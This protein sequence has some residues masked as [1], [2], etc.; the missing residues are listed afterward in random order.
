MVRGTA[1][2]LRGIQWRHWT[3]WVIKIVDPEYMSVRSLLVL[4][5]NVLDN[6]LDLKEN[7]FAFP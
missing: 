1:T 5:L 4:V 6:V 3:D 2:T 7:L